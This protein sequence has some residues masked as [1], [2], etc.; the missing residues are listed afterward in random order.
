ML[1]VVAF[2]ITNFDCMG[3]VKIVSIVPKTKVLFNESFNYNN[4]S[5]KFDLSTLQCKLAIHVKKKLQ[6]SYPLHPGPQN[7]QQKW[8]FLVVLHLIAFVANNGMHCTLLVSV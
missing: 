1:N 7:P 5:L 8:H 2:L 4:T 6:K 3:K